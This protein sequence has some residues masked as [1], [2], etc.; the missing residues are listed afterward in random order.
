MVWGLVKGKELGLTL[1]WELEVVWELGM[2]PQRELQKG[3]VLEQQW[4]V[5]LEFQ[6]EL[7]SARATAQELE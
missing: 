1:A 7:E 4:G 5:V 2:G 3:L 6:M